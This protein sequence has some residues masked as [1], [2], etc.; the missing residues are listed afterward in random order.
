MPKSRMTAPFA[1]RPVAIY[2]A[3]VIVAGVGLVI[4]D[5][6][7]E[8]SQGSLGSSLSRRP[9][10]AARNLVE[11]VVGRGTVEI[12]TLDQKTGTVTITVRD[13]VS[14]K[15]KTPAEKRELLSGE[16]TQAVES[17]LGFVS[18]KHIVLKLVK[19]GKVLAT[20]RGEPGKP[21]QTEFAPGLK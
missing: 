11:N 14:D 3:I 18:F 8:G 12:V 17:V 5:R 9:E 4:W 13:V 6:A 7:Y 10:D 2:V 20:V 1:W 21:P 15:G 16:G 19:D